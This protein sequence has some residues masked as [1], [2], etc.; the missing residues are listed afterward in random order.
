MGL[1]EAPSAAWQ[2]RKT[3]SIPEEMCDHGISFYE[4]VNKQKSIKVAE[5]VM[6]LR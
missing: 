3:S 6:D 2:N 5:Q 4:K 1:G